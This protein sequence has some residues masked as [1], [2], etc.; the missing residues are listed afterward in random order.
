MRIACRLFAALLASLSFAV[1][2]PAT[3][4]SQPPPDTAAPADSRIL[5]LLRLPPPHLRPGADYG[6][7]YGD[8]ASR[9]ARLRIVRALARRYGLT[10]VDDWPMPLLGLDCHVLAAPADQSAADLSRQLS[11]DPAILWA[12][13][14]SLFTT[15]SASRPVPDPLFLAQPATHAWRL[16]ELHRLADGRGVRVA[17]VDSQVEL[18][19]PD[20]SGQVEASANF[21]AKRRAVPEDHGTAV[22]GVIAARAGNGVGI[23]GVAPRARLLAFRACWQQQATGGASGATICDSFS[24]AKAI[25]RAVES[26]ATVLNL[27]LAGPNDPLLTQLL[28]LAVGRG[29][30]VVAAYDAALPGGGF[31]ASMKD[32]VAVSDRAST[33][34]PSHVHVAPGQSVPTTLAQGRWGLMNGSSI[35]AA[36]VSGL[37]ALLRGQEGATA[38][39]RLV[40]GGS[41]GVIDPCA[42]LR[43]LARGAGT[44]C[45][46][47]PDVS[48]GSGQ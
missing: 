26:R 2:G 16:A 36:H 13:P 33:D 6:G 22:A 47:A 1:G 14:V 25:Y 10:V 40:S 3:A 20:L 7:A 45:L 18:G 38:S 11:S 19:H 5:V 34:L 43:L 4:T 39:P 29:K 42:S 21:V 8:H 28:G 35:A 23:A 32:V 46:P 37:F 31:P 17:V 41:G 9:T 24:L 30:T 48:A 27:S 44:A 15:Q 12:Q